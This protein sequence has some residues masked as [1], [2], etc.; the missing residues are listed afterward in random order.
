MLATK[1]QR[2]SYPGAVMPKTKTKILVCNAGSSSLKFSL[3]D[4]GEEVLLADGEIDWIE[5]PAQ[6]VFRRTGQPE[7]RQSLKLDK[8]SDAAVRILDDLQAG[9]SPAL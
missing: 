5:K 1:S 6:L 4:A 3:F 9:S 2:D 7:I 8:H